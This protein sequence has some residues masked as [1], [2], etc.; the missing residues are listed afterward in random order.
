MIP[1]GQLEEHRAQR[2]RD[3]SLPV[4]QDRVVAP[5]ASV[6]PPDV[7]ERIA[8]LPAQQLDQL[9][10]EQFCVDLA[11]AKR[12]ARALAARDGVPEG[13]GRRA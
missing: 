13:E 7:L 5:G 1:H 11:D 4:V 8:H 2:E 9:L 12:R 10:V 3:F 6:C